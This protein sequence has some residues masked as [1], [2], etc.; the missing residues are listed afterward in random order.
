M[1][2]ALRSLAAVLVAVSL[3]VAFGKPGTSGIVDDAVETCI[4]EPCDAMQ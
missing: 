3:S 1:I 4:S 2:I